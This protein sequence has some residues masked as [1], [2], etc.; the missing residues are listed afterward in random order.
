MSGY[1]FFG[2]MVHSGNQWMSWWSGKEFPLTTQ[3]YIGV[4]TGF[5]LAQL[6]LVFMASLMLSYTV[7]R[8][9]HAMHDEA[10]KK[11]L[12]SPLAFFDTTPM[13]R[14]INR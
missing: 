3:E 6:A 4:Y 7:V 13:G 9:S 2:C 14:I 8:T 1:T 10:F 11:V 5:A 12:Y